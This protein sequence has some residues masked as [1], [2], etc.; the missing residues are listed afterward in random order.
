MSLARHLADRIRRDG[1]LSVA[2][3]MEE[4]LGHPTFG[5]YAGRD[6]L[7]T[8]GDFTTA[9][10]ISQMFGE[11]LGLWAAVA[12]RQM[13]APE[14][15]RLV[16]LGPGRGSLMADA[17]RAAS[18][19]PEFRRALQVHFVEMSPALKA[20]QG[21]TL[22]ARHADVPVTWWA[23]VSQVPA[24]P[25]IVLA[26]EFFDALP[27]R[28]F[29]KTREGWRERLVSL[30]PDDGGEP[31]FHFTFGEAD[32]AP[33]SIPPAYRGGE[34]MTMIEVSPASLR[35]IHT[36]ARR[37][38]AGR[39]AALIIDYG[40]WAK[41]RD[42]LQALKGHESVPVL[43]TPGGA[44]LTAHVDFAQLASTAEDAGA[45]VFGTLEQGEFLRR[46]GIERRAGQL[47]AAAKDGATR[48]GVAAALR[49]L[50][51]SNAMGSLFKV[52]ALTSPG[53]DVPAGFES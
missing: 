48:G 6:P 1:P 37:L 49:R 22:A 4:A 3:Y 25:M 19:A 39:G 7:G 20:R 43:K 28:Q 13:G 40:H 38:A 47:M 21:E 27:I 44:D 15:V 16:E 12:W 32:A 33:R 11:L 30:A 31:S 2:R 52:L 42:T 24:G 29:L 45:R 10:E 35:A 50:T 36:I 53:Q 14:T 8:D 23:D 5:Y 9:P 46:L 17:L 26:N 18:R 51:Q 41:P 34:E